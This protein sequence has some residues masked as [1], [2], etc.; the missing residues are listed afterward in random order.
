MTYEN[1]LV[2]HLEIQSPL[3]L[4]IQ[5]LKSVFHDKVVLPIIL[6]WSKIEIHSMTHHIVK[7]ILQ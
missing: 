3:K 4:D 6:I 7:L 1:Q 2:N 5:A